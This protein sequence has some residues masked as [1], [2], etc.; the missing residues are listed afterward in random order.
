M[1]LTGLK[2][3]YFSYTF[4]T[5]PVSEGRWLPVSTGFPEPNPWVTIP[6]DQINVVPDDPATTNPALGPNGEAFWSFLYGGDAGCVFSITASVG[7]GEVTPNASVHLQLYATDTSSGP[8]TASWEAIELPVLPKEGNTSHWSGAWWGRL[9]AGKRA[10]MRL[11]YWH[12]TGPAKIN[13]AHV[14]GSYW[15]LP[16]A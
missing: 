3:Y 12:A 2:Q 10:R 13:R 7:A 11:D 4:A 5:R 6:W 9:A 1:E 8:L 15:R 16:A 14:E